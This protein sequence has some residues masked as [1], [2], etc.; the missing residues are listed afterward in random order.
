MT[1]SDL[2]TN[3]KVL[4]IGKGNGHISEDEAST[5]KLVIGINEMALNPLVNAFFATDL[6]PIEEVLSHRSERLKHIKIAILAKYPLKRTSGGMKSFPS[7]QSVLTTHAEIFE[8]HDISTKYF[9][10][11]NRFSQNRQDLTPNLVSVTALIKFLKA[12]DISEA[13]SIGIG[14]SRKYSDFVKTQQA[15]QLSMGYGVQIPLLYHVCKDLQFKLH[16]LN[17]RHAEI[18][19]ECGTSTEMVRFLRFFVEDFLSLSDVRIAFDEAKHCDNNLS[20]SC[21]PSYSFVKSAQQNYNVETL[22][23]N[24]EIAAFITTAKFRNICD[25]RSEQN[26]VLLII[27]YLK[28]NNFVDHRSISK[29]YREIYMPFTQN[30]LLQFYCVFIVCHVKLE[31]KTLARKFRSSKWFYLYQKLLNSHYGDK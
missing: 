10:F 3:T 30:S 6:S 28:G 31:V 14:A 9:F 1:E 16:R 24:E 19:F 26:L 8:Q 22:R 13:S 18:K 20:L 11:D 27:L 25:L 23:I 21:W 4:I 12:K 2:D 7:S 17:M 29:C 5:F 15:T